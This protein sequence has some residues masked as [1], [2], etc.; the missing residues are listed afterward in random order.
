MALAMADA[1]PIGR[2]WLPVEDDPHWTAY[3]AVVAAETERGRGCTGRALAWEGAASSCS[4]IGYR[5]YEAMAR[6]RWVQAL[7]VKV[8]RNVRQPGCGRPTGRA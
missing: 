8:P 1:T 6:W 2:P 4:V 3:R 7:L 5:W